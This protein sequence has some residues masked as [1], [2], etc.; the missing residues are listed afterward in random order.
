M[1]GGGVAQY[2][3]IIVIVLFLIAIGA[4]VFFMLY[5]VSSNEGF[6]DEGDIETEDDL[7][8]DQMMKRGG[9]K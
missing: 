4:L 6:S 2:T 5:K 8:R 3:S 9:K 7:E 1:Q